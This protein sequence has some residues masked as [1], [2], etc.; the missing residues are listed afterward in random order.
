MNMETMTQQNHILKVVQGDSAQMDLVRTG[1]ARLVVTSP[2]Y[3]PLGMEPVRG[4]RYG[5]EGTYTDTREAVFDLAR[6]L[7]GV[8]SECHRVL[9]RGGVLAMQTRDLPW[10]GRFIPLAHLHR[11][12]AE[13][14]GLIWFGTVNWHKIN[15]ASPSRQFRKRPRVG[16]YRPDH[17]E[18]IQLFYKESLVTVDREVEL[19]PGDLDA[20]SDPLWRMGGAGAGRLHPHQGPRALPRRMVALYTSPGDLVVDPFAGSG[21][22][23]GEAYRMGRSAIGY[24]IDENHYRTASEAM[25]SLRLKSTKRKGGRT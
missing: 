14:S 9:A 4:E 7:N 22:F 18:E 20:V 25:R 15:R 1:E 23:L 12:M 11:E 2:P 24:E 8:F 10:A 13:A 17:V 16:N 19:S 6:S 21:L 3:W 5:S